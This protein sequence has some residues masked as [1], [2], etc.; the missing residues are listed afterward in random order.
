MPIDVY[1]EGGKK[2]NAVIHGF[3]VKTDQPV[4]A[5]GEDSAPAPF[6]LFLASLATC[7]GFYVKTFCDQRNIPAEEITLSMD[8]EVNQATHLIGK[9]AIDINVPGDFPEKY[10]AAVINAAAVCTVK[11]HLHPDI[12]NVITV[13]RK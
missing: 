13:K 8:Y 11:R 2:V 5:G 7:A 3:T 1:F 10:E 4:R 9:I 12:Q 6:N